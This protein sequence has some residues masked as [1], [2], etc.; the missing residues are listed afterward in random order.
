M[1]THLIIYDVLGREI[2]T[3]IN[4]QLQPGTYETE[5]DA[6]NIASGVYF[7]KLVVSDASTPLSITYSETRKMVMVK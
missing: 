2:A 1:T 5:W 7:Y 4:E 6:S 3:L